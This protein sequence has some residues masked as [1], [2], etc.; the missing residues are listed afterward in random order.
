M[1]NLVSKAIYTPTWMA[2]EVHKGNTASLNVS[3]VNIPLT[4]APEEGITVT[5]ADITNYISKNKTQ[6]TRTEETRSIEF[7]TFDV[8]PSAQDS[9]EI[10]LN[11]SK[12]ANAWMENT[13]PDSSFS[14]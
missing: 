7:V 11:I 1:N 4:E 9:A 10:E 3:Y 6:F 13:E 14:C 5:D 12:K 2:E 8:F